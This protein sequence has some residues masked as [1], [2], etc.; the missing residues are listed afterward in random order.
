[1]MLAQKNR[2]IKKEDFAR[3]KRYGRSY[4]SG[5]VEL[6]IA[7]NQ[8]RGTRIGFVVGVQF[9]KKAVERNKVKRWAREILR[10]YLS[11]IAKNKDLLVIIKKKN[12]EK[13]KKN[14]IKEDIKRVLEKAGI[15]D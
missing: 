6:K 7:E 12:T 1:M 15:N 3:I 10:G 13:T 8:A 14:H 5:N 2:I 4:F 9:S 11:K